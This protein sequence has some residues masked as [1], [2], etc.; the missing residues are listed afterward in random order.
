[1][2]NGIRKESVN[3][4]IKICLTEPTCVFRKMSDLSG[5]QINESMQQVLHALNVLYFVNDYNQKRQADEWLEKFQER[6]FR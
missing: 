3:L 6:V 2:P 1:V 4:H 5:S